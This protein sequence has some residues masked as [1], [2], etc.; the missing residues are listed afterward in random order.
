M[1]TFV[2]SGETKTNLIKLHS[3]DVRL[4]DK[5]NYYKKKK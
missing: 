1:R 4:G 3:A 2:L 5:L